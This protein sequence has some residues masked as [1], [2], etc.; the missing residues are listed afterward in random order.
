M[1]ARN[2][3]LTPKVRCLASG[4]VLA[5]LLLSLM[6][7]CPAKSEA[8]GIVVLSGPSTAGGGSL[9]A[10]NHDAEPG[11]RDE[12][13]LVVPEQGHTYLGLFSFHGDSA[14]AFVAG[15]NERGLAV[16]TGKAR[17]DT[18]HAQ[19]SGRMDHLPGKLL[20]AF[21]SVEQVMRNQEVFSGT[22]AVLCFMADRERA[23]TVER[24]R[25][26]RLSVRALAESF[27]PG[28]ALRQNL[29]AIGNDREGLPQGWLWKTAQVDNSGLR[30]LSRWI[31]SLP[32]KGPPELL[33]K[34][35]NPDDP[36]N[37]FTI[38]L[39]LDHEFWT[40]GID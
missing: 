9:L 16:A 29:A 36:G 1:E 4:G 35:L 26:G 24:T 31:V 19:G 40:A 39:L 11:C 37:P 15:I 3:L 7:I 22:G 23:V 34:V 2:L 8:S 33:L 21:D 28:P 25:E 13:R 18:V 10:K 12:L 20:T 6:F 38:E 17:H 14:I 27:L 5:A 30:T 32:A